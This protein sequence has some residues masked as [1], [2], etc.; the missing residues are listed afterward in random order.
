MLL[1]STRISPRR[2]AV[3]AHLKVAVDYDWA[4]AEADYKRAIE[5]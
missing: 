1:K 3:L 2:S 4:G 5:L